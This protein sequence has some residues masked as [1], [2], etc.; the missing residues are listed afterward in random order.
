MCLNRHPAMCSK[1]F[2]F[3]LMT[4]LAGG[5]AAGQT[6]PA[7]T[8]NNA[9]PPAKPGSGDDIPSTIDRIVPA[10]GMSSPLPGLAG[11]AALL[12]VGAGCVWPAA[13]PPASVVIN[14]NLKS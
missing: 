9:A 1:L 11:G 7:P 8:A 4:T 10:E 5:L 2:K 12:A 13:R 14:K 3:L 6:Q